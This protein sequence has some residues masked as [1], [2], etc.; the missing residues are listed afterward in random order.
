MSLNS[1][2]T[3]IKENWLLVI[4]LITVIFFLNTG[5]P[6]T[7]NPTNAIDFA[8]Y[9]EDAYFPGGATGGGY[10]IDEGF[11]PDI[12]ERQI[13][14]SASIATEV[15]RGTFKDSEQKIK[16]LASETHSFILH[17]N[18]NKYGLENK[19]YFQGTYQLKV[20]T[21]Q[22]ESVISRLKEIGE[23]SYFSENIDD[24]TARY[25]DNQI[26]LEIEK[27][28]LQKYNEMYEQAT[29]TEDKIQ[30]IDRIF[31]QELK[32]KY[33]EKSL[34]NID[35]KTEYNTIYVTL[36]E[37]QSDFSTIVP[38]TFSEILKKFVQNFNNAVYLIFSAIPWIVLIALIW[39]VGKKVKKKSPMPQ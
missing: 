12:E 9:T 36:T 22:Y 32:I 6:N 1:Q 5:F 13:T 15:K 24:I 28:R 26:N 19:E 3:K 25:T 7:P 38:L 35:Q 8:S 30:L 4:L 39:F 20:N 10:F 29:N 16:D 14:K 34:E 2:I 33:L 37:E 21:I 23:V 27:N 18:V 17:E 11:A 31:N